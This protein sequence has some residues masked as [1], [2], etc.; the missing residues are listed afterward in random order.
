MAIATRLSP[1]ERIGFSALL[2]LR[3]SPE[4]GAAPMPKRTSVGTVQ[5]EPVTVDR[6]SRTLSCLRRFVYRAARAR[7]SAYLLWNDE[8]QQSDRPPA[9]EA[10]TRIGI[11][12]IRCSCAQLKAQARCPADADDGANVTKAHIR[13]KADRSTRAASGSSRSIEH[14]SCPHLASRASSSVA[15]TA[16]RGRN[17]LQRVLLARCEVRSAP[18]DREC[19][20]L[21]SLRFN[22]GTL[23]VRDRFDVVDRYETRLPPERAP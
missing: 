17:R 4:P 22:R 19:A 10:D 23:S 6:L 16:P 2:R 8:T 20:I 5:V 11:V 1:R 13:P 9:S 12:E 3:P 14:A 18:S 21:R 7:T 15:A